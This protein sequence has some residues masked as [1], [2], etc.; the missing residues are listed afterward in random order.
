M[1]LIAVMNEYREPS[2]DRNICKI[3]TTD[4]RLDCVRLRWQRYLS[5]ILVHKAGI[6]YVFIP[7][8]NIRCVGHI[9]SK[10]PSML[11]ADIESCKVIPSS[12]PSKRYFI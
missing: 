10:E 4:R 8:K 6:K 1:N 5:K 11:N 7:I 9:F 3:N 12:Y 2:F